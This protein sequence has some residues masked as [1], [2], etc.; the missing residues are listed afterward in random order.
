V[1]RE[2][3]DINEAT[4]DSLLLKELSEKNIKAD[5]L[6][7]DKI[8]HIISGNKWFKLKYYLEDAVENN[9]KTI[10]TFGGAYSNHIIA[11]AYAAKMFGLKSIGIIRGEAP[12]E[13]SHT[14]L[15]A[16]KYGMQLEF[17][18]RDDYKRKK[19]NKFSEELKINF[20][21]CFVI[22][23][24]GAGIP[25]VQGSAEIL[26]SIRHH[27]Y[28]HI[29]CAIGTGTMFAGILNAASPLQKIIGV[30]VLKG[31][32]IMPDEMNNLT[33]HSKKRAHFEIIYDYHFGGYGKKNA[34]LI[35][36]MNSFY[37][38]SGIPTDFV[39]TGKLFYAAIDLVKKD[40]FPPGS[41][42]IIIHSGGLQGNA[43]LPDRTLLF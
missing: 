2:P 5:V 3:L 36:F 20:P 7:L 12:H 11:T 42:L 14:L 33:H 9:F 25:G 8:H 28:S 16:K 17:I 31:M 38:Q 39:Y 22:P 37:E 19:E 32:N 15:D 6:R 1:N 13:P 29:L 24:G 10:L 18:S 34:V 43:S 23:E 35:S 27:H 21:G 41:S 30:P 4:V 40:F 26:S